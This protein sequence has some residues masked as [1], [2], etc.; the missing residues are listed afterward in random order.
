[1]EIQAL[2]AELAGSHA[3]R[4]PTRCRRSGSRS[5][6]AVLEARC[7][8]DTSALGRVRRDGRGSVGERTGRRRGA[9]LGCRVGRARVRRA[10]LVVAIGEVGLAGELRS[11]SGLTR[12]VR[13]G[14]AARCHRRH[15]ARGRRDRGTP[16][17][18]RY[19]ACPSLRRGHRG[20][21]VD[22]DGVDETVEMSKRLDATWRV[23]ES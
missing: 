13:G 14:E 20:S 3:A 22:L 18:S 11:V 1:M 12:R 2:V 5:L 9:G 21:A 10:A 19:A 17:A 6:L 7:G 16:A 8:V 15:C 23:I 4:S